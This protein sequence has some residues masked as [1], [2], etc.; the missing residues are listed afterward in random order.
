MNSNIFLF[1]FFPALKQIPLHLEQLY[2]C[3]FQCDLFYCHQYKN[4]DCMNQNRN[5]QDQSQGVI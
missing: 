1:Y 3:I 2:L 4:Q 5:M